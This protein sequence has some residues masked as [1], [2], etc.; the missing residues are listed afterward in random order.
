MSARGK[1][2]AKALLRNLRQFENK[3]ALAICAVLILIGAGLIL[4][5]LI[6]SQFMNSDQSPRKAVLDLPHLKRKNFIPTSPLNPA[7]A[8]PSGGSK[9]QVA[10]AEAEEEENDST[11]LNRREEESVATFLHSFSA[12][13]NESLRHDEWYHQLKNL[14]LEP[15]IAENSNEDTGRMLIIRTEKSMEGTR[16]LHAQFFEDENGDLFAQHLSFEI[17]PSSNS[18][19]VALQKI[20]EIFGGIGEPTSQSKGFREWKTKNCLT[21]WM[22]TMAKEDFENDPDNAYEYPQDVGS[23]KVAQELDPHCHESEPHQQ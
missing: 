22:K 5:A 1:S 4:K 6:G 9:Q 14:G 15:E 12:F 10:G 23:I 19:Q 3:I 20:Q 11:H 17:R 16:Y 7:T 2:M 8:R 18:E 13:A 21:V